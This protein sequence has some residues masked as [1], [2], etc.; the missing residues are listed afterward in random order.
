[1]RPDL[2]VRKSTFFPRN[3]ETWVTTL[4]PSVNLILSCWATGN[5]QQWW[6]VLKR[7]AS[8]SREAD[9]N[10]SGQTPTIPMK[11]HTDHTLPSAKALPPTSNCYV[12]SALLDELNASSFLSD[13]WRHGDVYRKIGAKLKEIYFSLFFNC[14]FIREANYPSIGIKCFWIHILSLSFLALRC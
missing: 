1:M 14:G 6:H 3:R 4:K 9:V 11:N 12:L 7:R 2:G 5:K 10:L 13:L 8:P